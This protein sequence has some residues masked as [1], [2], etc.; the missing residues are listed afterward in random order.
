MSEQV[1]SL[2][3]E[4]AIAVLWINNPPVN[5]VSHAV[6]TA[7]FDAIN[8]TEQNP[9][10]CALLIVGAGRM[11]VAGADIKEFG[12]PPEPPLLPEVCARIETSPM[13]VVA[14]MHGAALG[15]GLEIALSAHYRI[16]APD[17]RMGLPEVNLGLIPGAG[18][19]QRL[20][21]LV[22]TEHAV[23]MIAGGKP[24]SAD[25]A[26]EMGL[27]DRLA[28]GPIYEAG[29]AYTK[30]L[31]AQNAPPRPTRDLPKANNID[32]NAVTE[33]V[34]KRA[35]GHTAPVQAVRAIK[36]GVEQPFEDGVRT[37]R[38]I[39]NTLV[40]SDQR[41]AMVHAFFAE[42][43]ASNLPDV[44]RGQAQPVQQ[45]GI[46]GGGTM[47]A[48]IACAALLA[49]FSVT[50]AEISEDA[51]AKA[52]QR[53]AT[54]IQGAVEHGKTDQHVASKMLSDALCCSTSFAQLSDA[55]LVIEAV[56]E[57]MTAKKGVFQKLERFC[58]PLAVL[59][60][61]TSYLDVA[62]IATATQ[63]ADRVVGL[64]F[65][66][67]AHVMKLVELVVP[68]GTASD[69]VATA[70]A[71]AKRLGKTAIWSGVCDGFIGNRILQRCRA[72]AD[73]MVLQGADPWQIDAA[74]VAF[75]YPMGPYA[76][77]DMA[78]LDI[79]WANRKRLAALHGADPQ[80]VK[81]PDMLCAA[82]DYGRKTGRGYYVYDNGS[83]IGKNPEVTRLIAQDRAARALHTRPF[84]AT[85][86]Q[87]KY[88]AAIVNEA[89]QIL[90]EGIALRPSDIDVVL[91]AGYGFPRFRGGPLFW[92]DMQGI[93]VVRDEIRRFA[94]EIPA[95]G[96]PA[97]LVDRLVAEGRSFGTMNDEVAT[98][99]ALSVPPR[100]S[101]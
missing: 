99:P 59:T 48:G 2:T 73:Q 35:R 89:A 11:F 19:T 55:D 31:L 47:G 38:K 72:V 64:H 1:T 44:A 45:I 36:A 68:Q 79:G 20:P 96:K 62:Q 92:A 75:G 21:R 15:G 18:G 10:V 42:R 51:C 95:V 13:V 69:A 88:M 29:L 65:F 85:D 41:R 56:V 14:A 81:F 17:A 3:V 26:L 50:V 49:G 40:Q 61:N 5:A 90:D 93:E 22:G 6:R 67:P 97:A 83:P 37:E 23:E 94:L 27:V 101:P 43:A 9:D 46:V 52:G 34:K 24:V 78:G 57:D 76:V 82:G 87:R 28:E 74:L 100:G 25:Q 66:S 54:L 77:A 39:F 98:K 8:L 12:L 16:C 91:M 70:F 84:D 53:I 58:K 33:R 63:R 71:V 80:A 30:Q 86:I 32:W 60:S 7:V 4:G